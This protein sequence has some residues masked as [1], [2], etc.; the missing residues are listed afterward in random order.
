MA[1]KTTT[2]TRRDSAIR[3][4]CDVAFN[5]DESSV[6]EHLIDQRLVAVIRPRKPLSQFTLGDDNGG[7]HGSRA[8]TGV[9]PETRIAVAAVTNTPRAPDGAAAQAL[10]A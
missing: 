10:K 7:T 6:G 3:A 1:K 4:S 9:V 8:F 2:Q 5:P